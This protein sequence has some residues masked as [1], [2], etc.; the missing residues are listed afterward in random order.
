MPRRADSNKAAVPTSGYGNESP[1]SVPVAEPCE[2]AAPGRGT[3]I[4]SPVVT[5]SSEPDRPIPLLHG[6]RT[7]E[8]WRPLSTLLSGTDAL[9]VGCDVSAGQAMEQLQM[10]G[11]GHALVVD[12]DGHPL[13]VVS[14]ERLARGGS[15][16]DAIEPVA[17]HL[18]GSVPIAVAATILGASS[19][20]RIAVL[21][22]GQ[23]ALGIVSSRDIL[24][25]V[26]REAGRSL[27]T[28]P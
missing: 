21:D 27:V 11:M 28:S 9:L 5:M 13:G 3:A 25:W 14:L 6:R 19:A 10:R 8:P 12:G 16:C 23:R 18:N 22:D 4:S 24:R 7:W 20:E 26:G 2:S 15:V 17:I 1:R